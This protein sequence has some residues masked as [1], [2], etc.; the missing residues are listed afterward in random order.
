MSERERQ[1]VCRAL[2][3]L[4]RAERLRRKWSMRR[5]AAGAGLTQAMISLLE[6]NLRNPTLDTLL[7]ITSVLELDLGRLILKAT[8]S[9]AQEKRK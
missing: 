2:V 4:L 7:R 5:L 9:A 8:A 1:A 3:E 6:N